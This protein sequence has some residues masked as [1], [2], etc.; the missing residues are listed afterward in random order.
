[1][2]VPR[3]RVDEQLQRGRR[4]HR[5]PAQRARAPVTPDDEEPADP[6]LMIKPRRCTHKN[7]R[8]TV[9]MSK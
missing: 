2:R 9:V 8:A 7:D 4:H 1:M 5:F 6:H 3:A